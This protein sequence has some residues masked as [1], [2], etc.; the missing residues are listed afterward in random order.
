VIKAYTNAVASNHYFAF[1]YSYF[2]NNPSSALHTEYDELPQ[3]NPTHANSTSDNA[4]NRGG[5][6]QQAAART[7]KLF[8]AD[9]D[10]VQVSVPRS[11]TTGDATTGEQ[12]DFKILPPPSNKDGESD[13]WVSIR[14]H[15][16]TISKVVKDLI[17]ADQLGGNEDGS[18]GGDVSVNGNAFEVNIC[19]SWRTPHFLC[20]IRDSIDTDVTTR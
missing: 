4:N 11:A 18:S 14:E 7:H 13:E 2:T 6:A 5:A 16:K 10:Y 15:E 17:D 9:L 8:C 12:D 1:L 20:S 3:L 19:Q